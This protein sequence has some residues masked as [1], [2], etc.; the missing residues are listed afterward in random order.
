MP[1]G[2]S[3]TCEGCGFDCSET[4]SCRTWHGRSPTSSG[5]LTPHAAEYVALTQLHADAVITLDG[6][7]AQAVTDLVVVAPIEVLS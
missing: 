4:A 1:S 7:L 2:G 6:Q 3:I 5:G